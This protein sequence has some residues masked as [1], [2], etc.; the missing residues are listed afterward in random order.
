MDED[1]FDKLVGKVEIV[2][3]HGLMN[4]H[5]F[6]IFCTVLSIAVLLSPAVFTSYITQDTEYQNY[7]LPLQKAYAEA[8]SLGV[9]ERGVDYSEEV[10]E[11]INATHVKKK[12]ILGL[13]KYV[14]HSNGTYIDSYI[15][16]NAT[17]IKAVNEQ[18]P[19]VFKKSDCTFTKYTDSSFNTKFAD[20]YSTMGLK[21]SGQ[22]WSVYDPLQLS[23]TWDTFTNSTDKGITIQR[24]HAKGTFDVTYA[25]LKDGGMKSY[26]QFIN[27]DS[28][29]GFQNTKVSFVEVIGNITASSINIDGINKWNDLV[30][31]QQI[32]FTQQ[33][34]TERILSIG[35]SASL[36]DINLGDDFSDILAIRVTKTSATTL[37][38]EIAF[39]VTSQN[40][41]YGEKVQNDP[42]YGYGT[43]TIYRVLTA[44]GTGASCPAPSTKDST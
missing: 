12:N 42:T 28:P 4:Y 40:L 27:G 5:S 15:T 25:K 10:I 36:F 32:V 16:T 19:I 34:M 33:N 30:I 13:S 31:D 7:P 23:C 38:L 43:G 18:D 2:A 44:S 14:L 20:Y 24:V 35:N 29:N 21:P 11:V 1:G 41:A 17:H 39:G 37:D 8:V 9:V 3:S 22:S 26:Q 6:R